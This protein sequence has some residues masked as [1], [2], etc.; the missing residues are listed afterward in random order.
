METNE[1]LPFVIDTLSKV[2]IMVR[3]LQNV[4]SELYQHTQRTAH[5]NLVN[6]VHESSDGTNSK[7]KVQTVGD[8]LLGDTPRTN[9][10]LRNTSLP[11]L[12]AM[13]NLYLDNTAITYDSILDDRATNCKSSRESQ[14]N[15][16]IGGNVRDS[17]IR[18]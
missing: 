17:N 3:L 12:T 10:T 9:S 15:A 7:R 2:Q 1:C 11:S 18:S 8:E 5:T 14:M 13:L 4:A 6:V 16:G